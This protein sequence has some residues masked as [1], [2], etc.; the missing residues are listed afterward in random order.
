MLSRHVGPKRK[1]RGRTGLRLPGSCSRNFYQI[2]YL[3]SCGWREAG[4]SGYPFLCAVVKRTEDGAGT[5][6]R[7]PVCSAVTGEWL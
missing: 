3:I 7:V 5:T 1:R 2:S 6:P 4:V